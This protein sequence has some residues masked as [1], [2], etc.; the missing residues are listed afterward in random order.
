MSQYLIV[1]PE[2][3][4]STIEQT[5][6]IARNSHLLGAVHDNNIEIFRFHEGRFQYLYAFA[7][8]RAGGSMGWSSEW[9]DVPQKP[10]EETT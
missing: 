2:S 5:D 1:Y 4:N 3:G 9:R 8:E 6:D 10:K 7:V